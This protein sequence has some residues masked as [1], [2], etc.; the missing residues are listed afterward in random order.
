MNT[1]YYIIH[2]QTLDLLIENLEQALKKYWSNSIIGYSFKTNSLPWI[3]RYMQEKGCYA[4]T[5]SKD[6]Y[7]LAGKLNYGNRIIYNGPIKSKDTFLEAIKNGCI[8]NIDSKR[9]IRWL[10]EMGVKSAVGIRINFDLEKKCPGESQCGDE[11][12]RFGFCYE[13]GELAD[14]ISILTQ[15]N[16]RISGLHMHCSSKTR[17]ID[18]YK[19][20]AHMCCEI[21]E[22]WKLD[23]DYIDIGGGFFGGVQGK[24]DFNKYLLNISRVLE[25]NFDKEKT[26]LIVEPGMSL[27][28]APVDYV[29]TVIDVKETT[30]NRFV[31][32]DGS[33]TNIDPLMRKSSY[34]YHVSCSDDN[35]DRLPK[36]VVSGFTC[37]E[38]DRLFILHDGIE[39]KENDEIIYEKV[40]AYTMCLTPLFIEMFPDVYLEESG[41]LR[42]VRERWGV[43]RI[44]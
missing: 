21:K 3:I 12:G 8:V 28:G 37:M 27:I 15:N 41:E 16:I 30:Y 13:N 11:G 17:S 5:V 19:A 39:L 33:R 26:K 1:P 4:E 44:L 42:K 25:K 6:E 24:P 9:E 14:V 7:L 32:T 34:T 43:E 22:K 23:I 38:N 2:K 20:I 10:V 18:I 31:I 36:Q 35:R 29:T 40:G